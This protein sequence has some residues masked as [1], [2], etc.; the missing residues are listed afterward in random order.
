M[1]LQN[2]LV[3]KLKHLEP[4]EILRKIGYRKITDKSIERLK[5]VLSDKLLG[6]DKSNFDFKYS[7]VEFVK[8]LCDLCE[9]DI[10]NY[11]DGIDK[12]LEHISTL[13]HA[14]WPQVF[15]YTGF[16]RKSQPIFALAFMEAR[17][18]LYLPIEYKLASLDDQVEYV[19]TLIS[20][21][22]KKTE[23][24]LDIWGEIRN[25]VFN[26]SKNEYLVFNPAGELIDEKGVTQNTAKLTLGNKD[27]TKLLNN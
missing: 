6:F 20:E 13:K 19:K 9:I 27:I 25:Y 2:T 22:Y 10:K 7:N 15:V 23:G 3:T 5:N 8:A 14:Y 12:Q 24:H 1:S 4:I 18:H 16:R 11:Q 17:R 21:H 26:F